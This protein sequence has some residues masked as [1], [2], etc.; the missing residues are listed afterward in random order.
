MTTLFYTRIAKVLMERKLDRERNFELTAS[1]AVMCLSWTVTW[2]YKYVA[3]TFGYF[4]YKNPSVHFGIDVLLWPYCDA[5]IISNVRAGLDMIPFINTFLSPFLI[6]F[7]NKN[8][9]EPLEQMK[10]MVST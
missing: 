3:Q 7:V 2:S 8:I 10:K 1:F 6:L 4:L 5:A 9:R